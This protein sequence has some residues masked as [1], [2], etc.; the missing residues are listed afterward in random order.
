MIK[1][2]HTDIKAGK[3][4]AGVEMHEYLHNWYEKTA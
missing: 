3:M 4:Y 1:A 2:D